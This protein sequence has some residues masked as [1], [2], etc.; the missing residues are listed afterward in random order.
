[1]RKEQST[2]QT[3]SCALSSSEPE[4][5]ISSPQ[6]Y[7]KDMQLSDTQ[8]SSNS[9][10]MPDKVIFP[11]ITDTSPIEES[12][13]N[14]CVEGRDSVIAF[15]PKDG[16][17]FPDSL[18]AQAVTNSINLMHDSDIMFDES[19]STDNMW[20]Y[21]CSEKLCEII[22]VGECIK[23]KRVDLCRVDFQI[24]PLNVIYFQP[25]NVN[26][27]FIELKL[28]SEEIMRSLQT[29]YDISVTHLQDQSTDVVW[30]FACPLSL[31]DEIKV[32]DEIIVRKQKLIRVDNASTAPPPTMIHLESVTGSFPEHLTSDNVVESFK[33]TYDD[34]LVYNSKYSNQSS[35]A[36]E[37]TESMLNEI[38]I[39]ECIVVKKVKLR[40]IDGAVPFQCKNPRDIMPH[41]ESLPSPSPPCAEPSV[42]FEKSVGNNITIRTVFSSTN[43]TPTALKPSSNPPLVS[44]PDE[45]QDCIRRH[46][47]DFDASMPECSEKTLA[48]LSSPDMHTAS[49]DDIK[50]H[51][52]RVE[53]QLQSESILDNVKGLF[54]ALKSKIVSEGYDFLRAPNDLIRRIL[55]EIRPLNLY[56]LIRALKMNFETAE[57]IKNQDIYLFIGPTGAGKSTTIH[58]LAGSTMS[59]VTEADGLRHIVPSNFLYPELQTFRTSAGSISETSA[60]NA[61]RITV[62]NRVTVVL[63]D[64]PGFKDTR[65]AEV[66]IANG[67]GMARAMRATKSVKPVIVI[68]ADLFGSRMDGF[69]DI[70]NIL[71]K[72]IS[73]LKTNV[74]SFTYVF[75]KVPLG[76]QDQILPKINHKLKS[77]EAQERSN[78]NFVCLLEDIRDKVRASAHICLDPIKSDRSLVISKLLD[79]PVVRDPSI[80]FKDFV[81]PNAVNLINL[82]LEKHLAAVTRAL[83]ELD[84]DTSHTELSINMSNVELIRYKVNELKALRDYIQISECLSKYKEM[85]SLLSNRLKKW[86]KVFFDSVGNMFDLEVMSLDYVKARLPTCIAYMI[87]ISEV[88]PLVQ[89]RYEVEDVCSPMSACMVHMSKL[90]YQMRLYLETY[91]AKHLD[92]PNHQEKGAI[93]LGKMV[94]LVEG[95]RT[96]RAY[97]LSSETL[98]QVDNIESEY[99]VVR[100][101]FKDKCVE[102]EWGFNAGIQSSSFCICSMNLRVIF[103]IA[104]M[105]KDASILEHVQCLSKLLESEVKQKCQGCADLFTSECGMKSDAVEEFIKLESEMMKFLSRSDDLQGCLELSEL[106]NALERVY[107]SIWTGFQAIKLNY[108]SS[109]DDPRRFLTTKKNLDVLQQLMRSITIRERYESDYQSLYDII[110]KDISNCRS[111]CDNWIKGVCYLDASLISDKESASASWY[112]TSLANSTCILGD[113]SVVIQDIRRAIQRHASELV[114]YLGSEDHSD[115]AVVRRVLP[116]AE[117]FQKALGELQ[118][119]QFGDNQIFEFLLFGK[120]VLDTILMKL[121]SAFVKDSGEAAEIIDMWSSTDTENDVNVHRLYVAAS[122]LDAFQELDY[123]Y[124]EIEFKLYRKKV[125]NK[126]SMISC[127][128]CDLFQM[129]PPLLHGDRQYE[130]GKRTLIHLNLTRS[131]FGKRIVPGALQKIY[132]EHSHNIF[133][134]ITEQLTTIRGIVDSVMDTLSPKDMHQWSLFVNRMSDFDE[135]IPSGFSTL[136]MRLRDLMKEAFQRILFAIRSG[137]FKT[138]MKELQNTVLGSGEVMKV[139][140]ELISCLRNKLS[141][142]IEDASHNSLLTREYWEKQRVVDDIFTLYNTV[143]EW[144]R[145][146]YL[147]ANFVKDFVEGS[148]GVFTLVGYIVNKV[149][150]KLQRGEIIS[151]SMP[152]AE[153]EFILHILREVLDRASSMNI[154]HLIKYQ[155]LWTNVRRDVDNV[156]EA[157]CEWYVVSDEEGHEGLDISHV[158]EIPPTNLLRRLTEAGVHNDKYKACGE[159]ISSHLKKCFVDILEGVKEYFENPGTDIISNGG[160]KENQRENIAHDQIEPQS[161]TIYAHHLRAMLDADVE[162]VLLVLK[163]CLGYLPEEMRGDLHVLLTQCEAA[164]VNFKTAFERMLNEQTIAQNVRELI[165][166]FYACVNH[167]QYDHASKIKLKIQSYFNEAA[168][169]FRDDLKNEDLIS[170]LSNLPRFFV[171]WNDYASR[172]KKGIPITEYAFTSR[173]GYRTVN[174]DYLFRDDDCFNL[175][176]KLL[177][178]VSDYVLNKPVAQLSNMKN[179]F[180]Y[181]DLNHIEVRFQ[182]LVSFIDLAHRNE[183]SKKLFTSLKGKLESPVRKLIS[184]LFLCIYDTSI[185]I[186]NTLNNDLDILA[187]AL[188]DREF[189]R[190]LERFHGCEKL[191]VH[192]V[193]FAKT[194][195]CN[196]IIDKAAIYCESIRTF[197]SLID[198]LRTK[199]DTCCS[200]ILQVYLDHMSTSTPLRKDRDDF[201]ASARDSLM[202][203]KAINLSLQPYFKDVRYNYEHCVNHVLSQIEIFN[204]KI[205]EVLH[206]IIPAHEIS[207][208]ARYDMLHGNLR[209]I[210]DTFDGMVNQVAKSKLDEVDR[211]FYS[212]LNAYKDGAVLTEIQWKDHSR[213]VETVMDILIELKTIS[214]YSPQL[215]QLI[216]GLIN[217]L[218]DNIN[219]HPDFGSIVI[220]NLGI[221]LSNRKGPVA[222]SIISEHAAFKNYSQILYTT[223]TEQFTV[224]MVLEKI[225]GSSIDRNSIASLKYAYESYLREYKDIVEKAQTQDRAYLD[226]LLRIMKVIPTK[227]VP[228]NDM[229]CAMIAHVSAYW[230]LFNSRRF[231]PDYH[232]SNGSESEVLLKPHASQVIALF[233]LFNLDIQGCEES[234]SESTLEYASKY[235]FGTSP[236]TIR[237]KISKN[238]SNHFIEIPTGEGKS[239]VLA[240]YAVVLSLLSF[241]VDC[242]CYSEYLAQRDQQAFQTFFASLNTGD[243]IR[244]GTFNELC[245]RYLNDGGNIREE[246]EA[247][248]G[249]TNIR[250]NDRSILDVRPKILLIDE[251]DVFFRSDFYGNLYRPYAQIRGPEITALIKYIWSIRNE[252]AKLLLGKVL[253]TDEYRACEA[254]YSGWKEILLES[255]KALLS[256]LRTYES[257]EYHFDVRTGC[258]GYKDQDRIAVNTV[259]GYKTLFA[260]FK[261]HAAKNIDDTRL[262]SR[263]ALILDC[264][265]FSYGEVPKLYQ[266]IIGVTGTLS[267]LSPPEVNI[268][269]NV[270][271]VRKQ[272]IMPS[273]YGNSLLNKI[274]NVIELAV[275]PFDGYYVQLVNEIKNRLVGSLENVSRAVLV[276]FRTKKELEE[277]RK[278][279]AVNSIRARVRVITED[280]PANEREGAIKQAVTRGNVTLLTRE[281]GRG[282]DFI[283]Y[284]DQLNSTGG[285]HVIQT[286]VSNDQAEA[287]QIMGRTSRQG[288]SGSISYFFVER[289]L[290]YAGVTPSDLDGLPHREKLLRIRSSRMSCFERE[291]AVAIK[292]LSRLKNDHE[293]SQNFIRWVRGKTLAKVKDFLLK[294]NSCFG[295]SEAALAS[296]T[297]LL[298]D[299]TGSMST[300]MNRAKHTVAIMFE[301]THE[302][303]SQHGCESAFELQLA[304]YRN[305]GDGDDILAFSTWESDPTNLRRFMER[306]TAFGGNRFRGNEAVEVGLQH[307]NEEAAK[308][309]GISQVIIIGDCPPNES[310]DIIQNKACISNSSNI[311]TDYQREYSKL[312]A[313]NIPI[314]AFYVK[315]YAKDSFEEMA[316]A[317]GGECSR[318]DIETDAGGEMLTNLTT[319]KILSNIGGAAKGKELVDAYMAKYGYLQL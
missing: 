250:R 147:D 262:N 196:E 27:S 101:L 271:S 88:A 263:I 302:I 8:F 233:R 137:E 259:Y 128:L 227:S 304:V 190:R 195:A 212:K 39:G 290:E 283:V 239:V 279:P 133:E 138:A 84:P 51:I 54:I 217:S 248:F 78:E 198:E 57:M 82:Q 119:D 282:T 278:S 298:M 308:D 175:G 134:K 252:R 219:S 192:L 194:P 218:L 310:I 168:R 140:E 180:S 31:L 238:I 187:C 55:V 72:F 13:S 47:V 296:R 273:V 264:G 235:V 6:S 317:T 49:L 201:Y 311:V 125:F 242:V 74:K 34:V 230:T 94:Y 274:N 12:T 79:G 244:Y 114:A 208:Y 91:L 30:A 18:D 121:Q 1:M 249:M 291:Y 97:R 255:V 149:S 104:N 245:E 87:R 110:T 48:I 251:V 156:L 50:A 11:T 236:A 52:D 162:S 293:E 199:Y 178:S 266:N 70:C 59:E 4:N 314:H 58:F 20:V 174:Y 16:G 28:T 123:P 53:L 131:K 253:L 40:R 17:H 206:Q 254:R 106:K 93:M 200:V 35:W 240:L 177:Q 130:Y 216:E 288:N 292:D 173:F 152:F 226:E 95:L 294:R 170:V 265:C 115:F 270:Y 220:G 76:D 207:Y 319:T 237:A 9:D 24:P 189:I 272:T 43:I 203:V 75:T 67:V 25:R 148:E 153:Y 313:K 71:V 126:F 23:V 284:D 256:D 113:F 3:I 129:K 307:A 222:M 300:L 64:S 44:Q 280:M 185:D 21:H 33:A 281:Y 62:S 268:I 103:V 7:K 167:R 269:T 143:I 132:L 221:H 32:G 247:L 122:Y 99:T 224:D 169:R 202:F 209:S 116:F 42:H 241:D 312:K 155:E 66:D 231:Q 305:Y 213:H 127:T 85:A 297:I 145:E 19:L 164:V 171:E 100:Q 210:V 225:E 73:D 316:A 69:T 287:V 96:L 193:Q 229:I 65:G 142:L 285:V 26:V 267:T 179:G 211:A 214:L 92:Q 102:F 159:Q 86:C 135:I 223:K 120:K 228:Y 112:L 151:L 80:A 160:R 38:Q 41:S 2:L 188:G 165:T 184:Q 63:C 61:V 81:G 257:H 204:T 303:L 45:S 46:T 277:F 163:E 318:L 161:H 144:S 60:I 232:P 22:D 186:N 275:V 124:C 117:T 295:Y 309:M 111:Y 172:L 14:S 109:R 258:I 89:D 166:R 286:F 289:E 182:E 150:N 243:S 260:Y 299:A 10:G 154:K 234:K 191:I 118:A 36:F 157:A 15:S 306:T 261:E 197:A 315:P 183:E 146:G 83:D 56:R 5:Q 108:D 77:L 107:V 301:R 136:A 215:K 37:C 90:Q 158:K 176:T 205:H 141:K 68:S 29:T 181:L 139:S 246:V 276:F 98:M 105:L